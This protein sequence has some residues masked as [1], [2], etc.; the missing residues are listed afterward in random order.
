MSETSSTTK[1]SDLADQLVEKSTGDKVTLDDLI[2]ALDTRSYGPILL[3]PAL[4]AASPIG[5]VPGMSIVTGT[6]IV[7]I[8]FQLLIGRSNPWLPKWL[9][10]LSFERDRLTSMRKKY[11][12]WLK[13]LENPI[14]QRLTYL[15]EHPFDK[16]IAIG[17]IMLAILFYPL[18]LVPFGVFLPAVALCLFAL[19][20]SAHDGI[21]ALVAL[22][23]T[24]LTLFAA[25]SIL[26]S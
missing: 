20:L 10:D 14:H 23:L 11:K 4:L 12:P 9:L 22:L 18:A 8:A 1:L 13:W 21:L 19:S 6:I 2:N 16:V 24:L 3:M 5:A 26:I 7:M 25:V 17:C 15:V